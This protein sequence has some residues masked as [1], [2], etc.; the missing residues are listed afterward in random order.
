[1]IDQ[2]TIEKLK[3]IADD[4]ELMWNVGRKAIE[5]ALVELRDARISLL[6]RGNGLVI[7]EEDGTDSDTIRLGP[8]MALSIGLQ[9]IIKHLESDV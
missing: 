1:M 5:D 2:A 6:G 3:E 8:E 9:A 4:K 7:R